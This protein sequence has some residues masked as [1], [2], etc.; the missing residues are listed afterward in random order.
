MATI[1]DLGLSVSEMTS[2]QLLERLKEMRHSRRTH[3][4][5]TKRIAKAAKPMELNPANLSE[6]QASNLIAE[7]ERMMKT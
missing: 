5:P 2:Q 3:K 7:L 6:D 4:A 1:N